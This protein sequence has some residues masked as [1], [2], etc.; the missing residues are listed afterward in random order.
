MSNSIERVL[1][2]NIYIQPAHFILAIV[3]NILNIRILSCRKLLSSSCTYYFLTYAIISIVYT[4]L[5]CPIQFVRGF[6]IN[7]IS[8]KI[9]CKTHAY[10]LFVL[11]LQANI[12]LM[13]A[14]FHRYWTSSRVHRLHSTSAVRIGRRNI[15]LGSLFSIVYMSPMLFIYYWDDNSGKCLTKFHILISIYI[16]SQVLIYYI[17]SPSLM[18]LFGILTILNIRQR[19]SSAI[20]L[21]PLMQRRRT[22]SQLTRMLIIQIVVHLILV[23]PFGIIYSINSIIPST[24]TPNVIAVRLVFV[25][26]QQCDYFA[27]FFLYTL[28]AR[29]YRQQLMRI[30]ISTTCSNARE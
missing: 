10:I 21:V 12:M 25:A 7:W 30:L 17:L 8:G 29:V 2:S 16:L 4:C 28:S 6:S 18:I 5:L 27:S 14:S 26:L 11:P 15:T 9:T 23:L 22:E 20:F 3:T 1:H 13:L 19:S 24:R